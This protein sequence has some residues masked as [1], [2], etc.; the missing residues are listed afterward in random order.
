MLDSRTFPLSAEGLS[1]DPYAMGMRLD[2]LTTA[3][4]ETMRD[5]LL[6]AHAKA[7]TAESYGISDRSLKRPSIERIWQQ[8]TQV[9]DELTRRADNAGADVIVVDFDGAA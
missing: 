2:S 3:Q 5:N 7:V 9:V 6:A 8:L 4:L 1:R